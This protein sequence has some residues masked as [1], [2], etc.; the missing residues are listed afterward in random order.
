[1][2]HEYLFDSHAPIKELPCGHFLH[3]SCFAQYTR[4]NYTCPVCCKSMGDMSVYFKMIDSLLAAEAARLPPQYAGR[5]QAV[6]C[7]DCGRSGP[8]PW[9][10]VYHPCQACHSYNTRVL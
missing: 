4:Y 8:A 10:W 6:L 1:V 5:T 2:C 7:H 3:S 9:H